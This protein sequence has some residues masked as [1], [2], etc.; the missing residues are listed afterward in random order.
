[1]NLYVGNIAAAVNPAELQQIFAGMGHVLY[2]KLAEKE[3]GETGFAFVYVPNE[4]RA[5]DAVATLNGTVLKG[6]KLTVQKMS[7]RPGV[8]GGEVKQ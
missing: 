2:A 8:V 7:E 1:M 6:E 4:E 5:R 3:V